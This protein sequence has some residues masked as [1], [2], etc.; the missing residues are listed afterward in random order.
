MGHDKTTA[1]SFTTEFTVNA[2]PGKLTTIFK[3][4][5]R[6]IFW[7]YSTWSLN[8]PL[9]GGYGPVATFQWTEPASGW[10]VFTAAIE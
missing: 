1:S 2:K 10:A 6:C 7:W 5:S 4:S 8:Q 9:N 3:I